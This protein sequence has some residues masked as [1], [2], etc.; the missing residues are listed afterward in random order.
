MVYMIDGDWIAMSIWMFVVGYFSISFILPANTPFHLNKVYMSMQMVG[1]MNIFEFYRMGRYGLMA[2][3]IAFTVIVTYMI[4]NQTYITEDQFLM[5]MVEHHQM[6]LL[7]ATKVRTQPI[8]A[9]TD[10]LTSNIITG[11]QAEINDILRQTRIKQ[12]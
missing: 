10:R 4:R 12:A 6:A 3:A 11:Q 1:A 2:A 9:F 8:S 7:M 5:G